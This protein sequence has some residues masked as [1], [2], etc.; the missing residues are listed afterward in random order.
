LCVPATRPRPVGPPRRLY[1]RR[2]V[3][4]R[5]TPGHDDLGKTLLPRPLILMPLDTPGHDD[6][7]KTPLLRPLILM[8]MA[9]PGHDDMAPTIWHRRY[10]KGYGARHYICTACTASS[11]SWKLGICSFGTILRPDSTLTCGALPC[12]WVTSTARITSK[13]FAS[14]SMT[15]F[16]LVAQGPTIPY[17]N[18]MPRNVPVSAPPIMAPRTAGGWSIWDMVL[19]T[20]STAATMPSAGNPSDMVCSAWAGCSSSFRVFFSSRAMTS[21][22]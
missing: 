13:Y 4:G 5:D 9:T 7:G 20:P 21:S 10:I 19:I 2:C 8:P 16:S 1:N 22:I 6:L 3:G 14:S 12:R 15:P 11:S 18:R 17:A